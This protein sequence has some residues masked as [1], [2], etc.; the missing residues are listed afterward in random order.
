MSLLEARI[1]D[2]SSGL[3]D[4]EQ[5]L[6]EIVEAS[7]KQLALLKKTQAAWEAE[8]SRKP[9]LTFHFQ[10]VEVVDDSLASIKPVF[11]NR[12]DKIAEGCHLVLYVPTEY[13]F[14]GERW[15]LVEDNDSVQTWNL[16]REVD[17]YYDTDSAMFALVGPRDANATVLREVLV[18]PSRPEMKYT[19]YHTTGDAKGTVKFSR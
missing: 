19:I 13:S 14:S 4:Y 7:D 9:Q 11:V 6:S 15:S 17:V 5:K 10:L 2:F 1:D 18:N 8:V 3:Q 16:D 12:G